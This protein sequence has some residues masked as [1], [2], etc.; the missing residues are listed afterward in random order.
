MEKGW[1]QSISPDAAP[2][3]RLTGNW[4]HDTHRLTGLWAASQDDRNIPS[5]RTTGR[6]A[7]SR[8]DSVDGRGRAASRSR[9]ETT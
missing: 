7:D 6:S 2:D 4:E 9:R 5:G 1:R 8:R 3:Q